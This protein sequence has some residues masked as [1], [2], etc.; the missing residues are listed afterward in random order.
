[1]FARKASLTKRCASHWGRRFPKVATGCLSIVGTAAFAANLTVTVDNIKENKGTVHV[2][3]YDATNWMDGDPDNFA[4]SQ[5]VDITARK[6][7]GPLVTDVEVEPGEYGAFI[8]HDLNS[9]FKFDKNFIRMPKE[10]YA[11]SGPFNKLRMPKFK[12]CMFVVGE[13]GAAI[14][15]GLQQ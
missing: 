11:F 8:Y 6:D 9:N 10:P 7:D 13:D 14:T 1:M 2:V 5:S 12:D 4:G 3:I 15:V